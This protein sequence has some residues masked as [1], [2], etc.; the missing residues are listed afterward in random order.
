MSNSEDQDTAVDDNKQESDGS[1]AT[2]PRKRN[3]SSVQGGVGPNL[4]ILRIIKEGEEYKWSL[5]QDMAS[6]ANDNSEKHIPEKDVKEANL[7]KIPRPGNLDPLK[8]GRLTV[9]D[10]ETENEATRY[11]YR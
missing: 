8:T 2:S 4:K 11:C 5:T 1:E 6:F 9:G 3:G 10:S 7:I